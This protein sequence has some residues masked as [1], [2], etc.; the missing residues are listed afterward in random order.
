VTTEPWFAENLDWTERVD[1]S[2]S[3]ALA[4]SAG[5]RHGAQLERE[6]QAAIDDAGHRAA[7][8]QALKAIEAADARA[9]ADTRRQE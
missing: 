5:L 8:Q 2:A 1:W 7:V 9:L 4:Y 6:R 3:P